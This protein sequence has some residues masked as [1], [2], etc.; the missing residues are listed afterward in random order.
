MLSLQCKRQF[1]AFAP[2]FVTQRDRSTSFADGP[3]LQLAYPYIDVDF[4]IQGALM[5]IL[6][7]ATISVLVSL[8]LSVSIAAVDRRLASNQKTN[9]YLQYGTIIG[10]ETANGSRGYSLLDVRRIFAAKDKIERVLIDFGDGEGK[11]LKGVPGY[12]HV[13]IEKGQTRI[14]IDLSQMLGSNINQEKIR[15]IFRG[16]TMVKEARINYDPVDSNITLQL[17]LKKKALLEVFQLPSQ[18]KPSRLVIDLKG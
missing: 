17:I 5:R 18:D 13:S 7:F 4:L 6:T 2:L 14:V 12:Y 1:W 10:G 15:Q 3:D 16:S 9:H 8:S 11:A